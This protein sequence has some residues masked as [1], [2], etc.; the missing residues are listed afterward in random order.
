M[1]EQPSTQ[2]GAPERRR[3]K[4]RSKWDIFKEA[5]L[6]LV[7]GALAVLMI[8]IFITGSLRRSA[9]KSKAEREASEQSSLAAESIAQE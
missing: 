3:R 7:I 9:A 6:P 4:P 8:V 2:T 5:Y 1:Q